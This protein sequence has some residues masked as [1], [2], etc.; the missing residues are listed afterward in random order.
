MFGYVKPWIPELRVREEATYRALYCG[1][2]RTLKKTVGRLSTLSLSYDF[3]FFLICRLRAEGIAPT[4]TPRRCILH[5]LRRRPM[6]DAG[7]IGELAARISALL[8]YDQLRDDLRD[9]GAKKRLRARLLLPIFRAARRRADLAD[10]DAA[11]RRSLDALDAYERAGEPSADA[12]AET[13]GTLLG[14]A[15][16]YGLTGENE[17]ILYEIGRH[18]GRFIYLA[19]AAEDYDD[20]RRRGNYNPLVIR[21]GGI[22]F[23]P[24]EKNALHTSLLL[25]L[26][27]LERAVALLPPKRDDLSELTDNILYIGLPRRIAYLKTTREE[28]DPGDAPGGEK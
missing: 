23:S 5:P 26:T 2:C 24:E 6:I 16:A 22:D 25:E 21:N 3:V 15:F 13:F 1:L 12:A 4:P 10:L 27:A 7:E 19:D 8:T 14:Q 28:R 18:V 17:R 11:F 9:R 20:D